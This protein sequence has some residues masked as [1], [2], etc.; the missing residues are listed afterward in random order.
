[1]VI[2]THGLAL[3]LFLMAWFQV[4]RPPPLFPPSLPPPASPLCADSA[5][6]QWTVEEFEETENPSN[7]GIAVMERL[8]GEDRC[9][10]PP[11]LVRDV[12]C[13]E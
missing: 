10:A 11:R 9:A 4:A 5:R 1:M 12:A 2:V 7:C 13:I 6:G 3:R 8:P